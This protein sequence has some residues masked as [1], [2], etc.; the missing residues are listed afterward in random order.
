MFRRVLTIGLVVLGSLTAFNS[1]HFASKNGITKQLI[2]ENNMF[3]NALLK[4]SGMSLS[5]DVDAFIEQKEELIES[6]ESKEFN[7]DVDADIVE[8]VDLPNRQLVWNAAVKSSV[9]VKELGRSCEEYMR[10]PATEC[11]NFSRF[12]SCV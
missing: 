2:Y 12:T 10:L 8:K 7:G 3:R 1:F 6:D 5:E 9:R 4:E 11:K